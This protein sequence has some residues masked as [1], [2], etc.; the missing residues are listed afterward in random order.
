MEKRQVVVVEM[1]EGFS[2]TK[3]T[4]KVKRGKVIDRWEPMGEWDAM[5]AAYEFNKL[6]LE[7]RHTIWAAVV[8][9]KPETGRQSLPNLP[10]L[11]RLP[12]QHRNMEFC[13]AD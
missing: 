7:H 5:A 2:P 8:K 13:F 4:E 6:V 10:K 11:P 9:V 1:P 12:T 3:A